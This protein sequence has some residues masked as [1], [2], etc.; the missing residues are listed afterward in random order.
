[1]LR[2][3]A[4]RVVLVAVPLAMLAAAPGTAVATPTLASVQFKGPALFQP[5]GGVLVTLGYSCYPSL[6]GNT[7]GIIFAEVQ[8]LVNGNELAGGALATC[9]DKNHTVTLDVNEL[10]PASFNHGPLARGPGVGFAQVTSD[11]RCQPEIGP[12]PSQ[13]SASIGQVPLRIK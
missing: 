2:T 3:L 7:S 8:S 5:D 12:C 1:M 6:P 9:D 4:R 10:P 11:F 13:N